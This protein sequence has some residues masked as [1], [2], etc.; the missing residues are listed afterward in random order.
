MALDA[1]CHG[2][3]YPDRAGARSTH[4]DEE[5][6]GHESSRGPGGH[7]ERRRA[8]DPV[9]AV[10]AASVAQLPARSRSPGAAEAAADEAAALS[11]ARVVSRPSSSMLSKSPGE[12]LEPVTATRIA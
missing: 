9:D 11:R 6:R 7:E 10:Q 12:I 1:C 4:E 3:A 8:T 2:R 5:G